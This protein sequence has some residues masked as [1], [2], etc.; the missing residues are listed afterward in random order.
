[1]PV[2]SKINEEVY[3]TLYALRG[4]I[5]KEETLVLV[6]KLAENTDTFLHMFE[7]L[8]ATKELT[9]QIMPVIPRLS[10]EVYPT[11]YALRGKIDKKETL[12][13][14][15]TAADNIEPVV[16]LL[17]IVDKYRQDGTLD[18][19]I[20]LLSKPSVGNLINTLTS[21]SDEEIDGI[22]NAMISMLG[23]LTKLSDPKV[24]RLL[25]SM[26]SA[27]CALELEKP[28]KTGVRGLVSATRDEDI[29]KSMGILLDLL[30]NLSRN[31]CAVETD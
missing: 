21:M 3:P 19:I 5:D 18:S 22:A 24:L 27:V 26:L 16:K 11:L 1:M 4:K 25:D 12:T 8:E 10:E 9:N 7:L 29:Q 30:R 31:V 17:S 20:E 15:E 14:L 6:E 28:K 23:L 13:L 2:I